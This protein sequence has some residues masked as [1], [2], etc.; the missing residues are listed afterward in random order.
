MAIAVAILTDREDAAKTGSEMKGVAGLAGC[1]GA[2]VVRRK[3]G[4]GMD[5]VTLAD[6]AAAPPLP[7]ITVSSGRPSAL[8][9]ICNFI[10]T[11]PFCKLGDLCI[12]AVV[13]FLS[14]RDLVRCSGVNCNWRQRL[15]VAVTDRKVRLY[16]PFFRSPPATAWGQRVQDLR[17]LGACALSFTPSPI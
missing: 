14:M 8:C 17:R 5:D 3:V 13:D 11:D 4:D 16:F 12:L 9:R 1:G 6:T 2:L 7:Q 10:C 15:G